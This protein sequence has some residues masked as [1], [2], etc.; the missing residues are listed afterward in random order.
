[1][2]VAHTERRLRY[3][4]WVL[5]LSLSSSLTGCAV[6][7]STH[8]THR[9][10]EL[11]YGSFSCH[12]DTVDTML[13]APPCPAFLDNAQRLKIDIH[14]AESGHVK[15]RSAELTASIEP[16]ASPSSVSLGLDFSYAVNDELHHV[17]TRLTA[18]YGQWL[19]VSASHD[20]LTVANTQSTQ[21]E[22]VFLRV[23]EPED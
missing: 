11:R 23:S 14:G 15:T 17:I 12:I 20:E 4:A 9:V 6:A 8:T 3:A 1:M 13:A 19:A 5:L 16:T 22:A 2:W 7:P 10:L 21:V 18:P